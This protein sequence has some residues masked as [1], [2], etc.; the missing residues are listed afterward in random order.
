MY[1]PVE[2]PEF[3]KIECFDLHLSDFRG[4]KKKDKKLIKKKLSST[5]HLQQ[6]A[7]PMYRYAHLQQI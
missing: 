6:Y 4:N 3:N 2:K 5:F 1:D 7:V